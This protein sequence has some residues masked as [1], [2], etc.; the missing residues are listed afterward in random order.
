MPLAPIDPGGAVLAAQLLV[1]RDAISAVPAPPP[2][3]EGWESVCALEYAGAVR[4]L[5]AALRTARLAVA[6]AAAL[7][8]A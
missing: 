4:R 7:L 1:L 3:L 2:A 5:E 8:A 6:D